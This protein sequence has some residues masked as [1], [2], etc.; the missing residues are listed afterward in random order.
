[1][2]DRRSLT[3]AAALVTG[4]GFAAVKLLPAANALA[5]RTWGVMV[6]DPSDLWALPMV[7]LAAAWMLR[8][9][10]SSGGGG[11]RQASEYGATAGTAVSHPPRGAG[12]ARRA[13]DFAAMIAAALASIATSKAPPPQPPPPPPPPP[14]V[15]VAVAE[16][17]SCAALTVDTCERTATQTL[18]VVRARSRTGEACTIDML[19]AEEASSEGH[20]AADLLPKNIVVRGDES[21]TFALTFLRAVSPGDLR[22]PLNARAQVGAT[23]ASG[24][25]RVD[26]VAI[27][28]DC[29]A[30]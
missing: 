17:P 23:G 25:Q 29:S 3:A 28:G 24:G 16:D 6:M 15:A 20:T 8:A 1:V 27:G 14:P 26:D 9:S 19:R 11:D 12:D 22:G 10:A 4:V 30:N 7:G 5:A 18:V 13:L 2:A 21:R